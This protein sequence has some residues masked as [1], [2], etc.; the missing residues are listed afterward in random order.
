MLAGCIM[1]GATVL[2]WLSDPLGEAYS[3]WELPID[4]G[5]QMPSGIFNYGLL[6]LCGAV[7]CFVIA[8][9]RW[10]PSL[11]EEA[12]NVMGSLSTAVGGI[13]GKR[14]SVLVGVLCAAPVLLF[15]WQYLFADVHTMD[16]LAQHGTQKLLI[17]QYLGYSL[18][19][20]L[21]TIKPF[22][23]HTSTFLTRLE[24]LTD[25][26]AF[27]LLFPLVGVGLLIG[28]RRSFLATRLIPA[29]ERRSHLWLPGVAL[30]VC[31][32]G[33]VLGRA[34]AAM[35]CEYQANEELAAGNY[36]SAFSWLDTALVL[37][38]ALNQVPY[39]HVD[40][41]QAWYFLHPGVQSDD[42]HV[43][44]ASLYRAQ[45][46]YLDSYQE[47][48]AVSH[49]QR[50][51]P[52]MIDELSITLARLAEAAQQGSLPTP[53]IDQ[54]TASLPWVQTLVQVDTSNI[55]GQYVVGQIRYDLHNFKAC[56]AQMA[57]VV[58]LNHNPDVQ[59]SAYTYMALSMAGL[60]N[61]V[62]ERRL[63]LRAVE[64][65]PYYHNNTAREALSG[66]R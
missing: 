54:D 23:V 53:G 21:V 50:T 49:E 58:Q 57:M 61:A 37:N 35:V 36:A 24:L 55:Y 5:W 38:P 44:L 19:G 6:C 29:K 42:S 17:Q 16:V 59:S 20:P 27:G 41:G 46:D 56:I 8:Y 64:L 9:G 22:E 26:V 45:G 31:I 28:Q 34:P 18:A 66:L 65:D 43:Y 40:R 48:L 13:R 2:P 52:W 33:I 14:F 63:L 12:A 7:L 15:L 11:S 47:L 4:I 39:F 30:C 32:L 10:K 1:I 3:A 62:D 60:G 51:S 25:Q